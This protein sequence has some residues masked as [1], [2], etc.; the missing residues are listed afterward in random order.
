M[1]IKIDDEYSKNFKITIDMIEKFAMVSGD[2]NPI[3]LDE[4]YAQN[5]IFKKRIAHG[6]LVGSF[7]STII[8]NYFP[9]K[10]TIYLS[11]SLK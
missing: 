7:I 6:L 1:K 8:G 4:E 9:G 11:Q 10:G 2:K 3:H 5:S